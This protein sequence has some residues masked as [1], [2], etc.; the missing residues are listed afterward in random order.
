MSA[1]N[2][3]HKASLTHR[4]TSCTFD[5]ICLV[6][7]FVKQTYK[8]LWKLCVCSFVT[9]VVSVGISVGDV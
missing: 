8:Y 1:L 2:I 5:Y 4:V 9:D 7:H 6:F 3:F